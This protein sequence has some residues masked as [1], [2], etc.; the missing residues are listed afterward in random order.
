MGTGFYC[1]GG[2]SNLKTACPANSIAPANSA[3][4][5]Q[6]QCIPGYEGANG[7]A[8][9]I[10]PIDTICNSGQLSNCMANGEAAV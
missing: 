3:L 8:C 1:A 9:T 6:C 10:C 4:I 7:T 5:T 2:N